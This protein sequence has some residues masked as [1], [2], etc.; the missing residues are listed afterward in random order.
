MRRS[1]TLFKIVVWFG[2]LL[3]WTFAA[4][5]LIINPAQLLSV[6]GLGAV[7]SKIW[8]FNYS[9]LLAILSAFY[10]PAATSPVRYRA[11]AYLLVIGRLVPA[12]TF[13]VGVATGFMPQGFLK[14]GFGDGAVGMMELIVLVYVLKEH[15]SG[16]VASAQSHSVS[17]LPPT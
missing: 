11:N 15:K 13:V 2:I 4:W 10:I 14:L 8:L 5:A 7:E 6:L 17:L 16:D 12:T 1:A 3:N 9:V